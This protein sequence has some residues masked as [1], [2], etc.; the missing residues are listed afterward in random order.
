MT[1]QSKNWLLAV[2]PERDYAQILSQ[3]KLVRL[4]K[5]ESLYEPD[6]KTQYTYF[7]LD[8]IVSVVVGRWS[9]ARGQPCVS[10]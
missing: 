6:A 5:G 2:L 9:S 7:P 10:R 4:E 1:E 3:S 8:T